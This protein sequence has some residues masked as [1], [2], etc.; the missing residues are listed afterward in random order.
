MAR[1]L[2]CRAAL[3]CPLLLTAFA[4][5]YEQ[6][7]AA[8]EIERELRAG[9]DQAQ[10]FADRGKYDAAVMSFRFS[11][12]AR[13][14]VPLRLRKWLEYPEIRLRSEY[15]S[16]A[17]SMA[18]AQLTGRSVR[19][20][21]SDPAER[22][23]KF[24]DE[25]E[26]LERDFKLNDAYQFLRENK[27]VNGARSGLSGRALQLDQALWQRV[28]NTPFSTTYLK[29][30]DEF[31]KTWSDGDFSRCKTLYDEHMRRYDDLLSGALIAL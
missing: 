18:L 29:W 6:R 10:A 15:A 14:A 8:R 3:A 22:V 27:W 20:R 11:W 17:A 26:R 9:I 13:A 2:Y 28:R 1:F 16:A 4:L 19:V 30:L 12:T 5:V 24:V 31:E 25:A 23:R 21:A 7:K